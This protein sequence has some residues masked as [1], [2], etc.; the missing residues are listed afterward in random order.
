LGRRVASAISSAATTATV[1]TSSPQ[2]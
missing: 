2:V 1:G